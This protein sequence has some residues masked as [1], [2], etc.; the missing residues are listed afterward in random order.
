MVTY[1]TLVSQAAQL[2]ASLAA[3]VEGYLVRQYRAE[4]RPS[5]GTAQT[6]YIDA[7]SIYEAS[8]RLIQCGFHAESI[9]HV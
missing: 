1:P 8:Q 4:C 9:A 6:V 3:D 2:S 7:R 5:D